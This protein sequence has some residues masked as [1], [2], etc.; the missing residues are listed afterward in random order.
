ME[1]NLSLNDRPFKAI[2]NGTKKIEGR[3]QTKRN[4]DVPFDKLTTRDTIIF[5]NRET[6]EKMEVKVLGVRHY[7]NVREMLEKEGVNNVLSSGGTIEEGI[8]SYNG[9]EGYKDG[10][11]KSGIYAIEV[12]PF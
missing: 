1:Y 6:K 3:V 11:E 12:E 8:E 2:K 9:L 5:T 4:L 7:K 10:I